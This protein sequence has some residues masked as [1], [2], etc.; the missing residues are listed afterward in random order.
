MPVKDGDSFAELNC[1]LVFPDVEGYQKGLGDWAI[2]LYFFGSL[3][4][5][6]LI[7][8][9]FYMSRRFLQTLPRTRLRL[10]IW[11][12]SAY[13]VVSIFTLTS[14]VLP[15]ASSFCW[16]MYRVFVGISMSKVVKVLR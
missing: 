14:I 16:A 6:I 15:Q 11:V 12:N 7:L 10:T 2:V 5:V 8:E 13:V 1:S 4:S 3:F 9:W